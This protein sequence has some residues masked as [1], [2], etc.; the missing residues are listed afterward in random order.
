MTAAIIYVRTKLNSQ[1]EVNYA[2]EVQEREC[3]AYCE[4]QGYE[5]RAVVQDYA[6]LHDSVQPGDVVVVRTFDRLAHDT[7][8]LAVKL[9]QLERAGATVESV[10]EG[11][12]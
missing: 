11:K 5:V 8:K 6:L 12:A 1:H 3:R 4:Q 7:R 2:K 10:V 9:Y